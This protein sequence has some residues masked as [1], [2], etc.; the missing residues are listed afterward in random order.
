MMKSILILLLLLT[1]TITLCQV[2]IPREYTVQ[3][4]YLSGNSEIIPIRNSEKKANVPVPVVAEGS[5]F[6]D[7]EYLLLDVKSI[8]ILKT[9]YFPETRVENDIEIRKVK[10]FDPS[11]G[12]EITLNA[13]SNPKW[14]AAQ[15]KLESE[16]TS[17]FAPSDE[18]LKEFEKS[19]NDTVKKQPDSRVMRDTVVIS[20]L[21]NVYE[22]DG[23]GNFKIILN[24]GL[25]LIG[26]RVINQTDG[27]WTTKNIDFNSSEYVELSKLN[28]K[29]GNYIIEKFL[30]KDKV[31]VSYKTLAIQIKEQ[32]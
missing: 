14:E 13:I 12:R 15:R 23:N 8:K 4:I 21:Q 5:I 9:T 32:Y 6:Y 2:K 3:V 16:A 24:S 29:K 10:Y 30:N 11:I 17:I 31:V 27:E 25:K 28:L 18:T 22:S 20:R 1:S 7:G 26:N 19:N